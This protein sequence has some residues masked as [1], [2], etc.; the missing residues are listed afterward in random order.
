MLVLSWGHGALPVDGM[1]ETDYEIVCENSRKSREIFIRL[2]KDEVERELC[3]RLWLYQK[4][5]E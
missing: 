1:V 2:A 5:R 4:S 3:T